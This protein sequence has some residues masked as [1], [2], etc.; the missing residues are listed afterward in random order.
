MTKPLSKPVAAKP[1]AVL[2]LAEG[3]FG[4]FGYERGLIIEQVPP[5]VA[6]AH[7]SWLETDPAKVRGA[8]SAGADVVHYMG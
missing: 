8:R 5:E 6:S 7:A 2:T 4:A 1:L 3:R